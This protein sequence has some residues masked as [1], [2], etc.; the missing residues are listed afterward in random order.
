MKKNFPNAERALAILVS[1]RTGMVIEYGQIAS[2]TCRQITDYGITIDEIAR[3]VEGALG[4]ELSE[5]DRAAMPKI[6][7]NSLAHLLE[8]RSRAKEL[9]R[10][11]V[12]TAGSLVG[13]VPTI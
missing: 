7:V 11:G 5:A 4:V 12:E 2:C 10:K 8:E 9:E 13:T 1:K 3:C 6:G